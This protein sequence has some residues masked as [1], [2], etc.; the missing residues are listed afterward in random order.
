MFSCVFAIDTA[1]SLQKCFIFLLL[2]THVS[3]KDTMVLAN[4]D[5]VLYDPQYWKTPY[6]FNPQNFLDRDGNFLMNEAFMPFS[7]GKNNSFLCLKH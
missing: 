2:N 4:L 6:Q 5:S 7:A 3:P 1:I